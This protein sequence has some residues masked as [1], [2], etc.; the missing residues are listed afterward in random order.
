MT[1]LLLAFVLFLCASC[2]SIVSKSVYN[3]KLNSSP[4][5]AQVQVFDRKGREVFNG[6]TPTQ[7]NLR[8]GSG[9]F[10]RAEYTIKYTKPG[11]LT[12]EVTISSD[13]NGWYFGNIV[14]GGLIGFLIVDPATGAMYRLDQTNLNETLAPDGKT[15]GN[16]ERS[17][18]IL[19]IKQ[20]PENLK[21]KLVEVK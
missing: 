4:E 5:E 8:S 18:R 15:T 14:F 9:Y 11:Y 3:V 2:A 7:V 19:D 12:K 6:N 21:A 13:I 20:V 1:K 10:K 17:L 16:T